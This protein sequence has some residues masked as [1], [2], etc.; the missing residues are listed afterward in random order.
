MPAAADRKMRSSGGDADRHRVD[1]RVAVV[2]GM[3]VDLAADCGHADAV[4]V[5]ADAAHHAID[6][7]A[8]AGC[9]GIAEAQRVEVGDGAGAHGED[10]AQNAADAGGGAL[11]GFDEAGVVVA[12][13]S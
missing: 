3:E 2:G 1:Q 9:G 11:V 4:A 7:A 10:I 5:A 12:I 13:P 8:G 6:D